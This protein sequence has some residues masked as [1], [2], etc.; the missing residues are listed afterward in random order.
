MGLFETLV[1]SPGIRDLLVAG[2]DV[3]RIQRLA[4]EEGMMTL[5]R[6]GLDKVKEGITT[7]EEVLRATKKLSAK[8]AAPKKARTRGAAAAAARARRSPPP[9]KAKPSA[10]GRTSSRRAV[11]PPPRRP[12]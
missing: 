11:A 9:P 12:G 10:S 2:A 5:R 7:L 8:K 6:N 4:L 1:V 3:D